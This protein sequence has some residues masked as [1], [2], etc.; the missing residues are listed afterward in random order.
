LLVEDETLISEM[1]ADAL[2]DLGF[3]VHAV[4]TAADALDHLNRG[5][6]CDVLFTDINL[7]GGTDGTALARQARELRPGLPVVYASGAVA[8]L[9]PDEAV[10][11]GTFIAKP[12]NPDRVCTMLGRIAAGSG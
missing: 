3:E 12:Y 6:P 8:R 10:P 7:P 11:G 9:A 1:M 4:A 5:A 2:A